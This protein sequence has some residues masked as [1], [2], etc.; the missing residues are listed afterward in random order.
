METLL[1]FLFTS[2]RISLDKKKMLAKLLVEL[3]IVGKN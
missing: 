3:E 2:S 1:L